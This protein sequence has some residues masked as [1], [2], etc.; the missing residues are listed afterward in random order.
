[1]QSSPTT[2]QKSI[3]MSKDSCAVKGP[4]LTMCSCCCCSL[5]IFVLPGPSSLDALHNTLK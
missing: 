2:L 1:M 5:Q 4:G 3:D